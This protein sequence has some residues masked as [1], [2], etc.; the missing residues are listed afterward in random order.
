M[1]SNSPIQLVDAYLQKL[2]EAPTARMP[3]GTLFVA[4]RLIYEVIEVSTTGFSR[5][6][7]WRRDESTDAALTP[8]SFLTRTLPLIDRGRMLPIYRSRT[9]LTN[10]GQVRGF[11]FPTE[12][13]AR[14]SAYLD[15]ALVVGG[16]AYVRNHNQEPA[17][18]VTD[19]VQIYRLYY[20][21]TS[22]HGRPTHMIGN[23]VENPRCELRPHTEGS[24]YWRLLS[25]WKEQFPSARDTIMSMPAVTKQAAFEQARQE[26]RK[27][28]EAAKQTIVSMPAVTPADL[29]KARREQQAREE[30]AREWAAKQ[31]AMN[32]DGPISDAPPTKE[33]VYKQQDSGST[34]PANPLQHM[35]AT[36]PVKAVRREDIE[37]DLEAGFDPSDATL[38]TRPVNRDLLTNP[39][40][41]TGSTEPTQERP[42]PQL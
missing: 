15:T 7:Q 18:A 17:F 32:T 28:D 9:E 26:Q 22:D 21:V 5:A 31:T 10:S 35:E 16:S 14:D 8:N 38:P 4:N 29:E 25:T 3:K 24:E 2:P 6:R 23:F 34:P 39:N 13:L 20:Y 42:K 30:A 27:R 41:S 11:I 19:G 1:P 33:H 40:K 37:H 12:A 36:Q